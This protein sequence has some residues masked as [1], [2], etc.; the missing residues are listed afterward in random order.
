MNLKLLLIFVFISFNSSLFCN[1][2][3]VRIISIEETGEHVNGA[4][5]SRL[6]A[7]GQ[8]E[9]NVILSCVEVKIEWIENIDDYSSELYRSSYS[10]PELTGEIIA[11]HIYRY[12][13]IDDMRYFRYYDWVTSNRTYY[14]Q[15][16]GGLEV[17]ISIP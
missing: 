14:Y 15:V 16:A 8:N 2:Y 9:P 10:N 5:D 4:C 3:L 1:P 17:S 6:L 13:K 7:I 12:Q 11:D